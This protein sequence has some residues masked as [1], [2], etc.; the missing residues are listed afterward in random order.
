MIWPIW[1][2]VW[3]GRHRPRPL[4][5]LQSPSQRGG[6]GIAAATAPCYGSG[7]PYCIGVHQFQAQCTSIH[8]IDQYHIMIYNVYVQLCVHTHICILYIYNKM[9]YHMHDVCMIPY[10]ASWSLG[11]CKARATSSRVEEERP[12]RSQMAPS[13]FTRALPSLLM[14][15]DDK[16]K[17][18]QLAGSC[19]EI[20]CTYI[21]T[22][23]TMAQ[24]QFIHHC[25]NEFV[26][27]GTKVR[28]QMCPIAQAST[29]CWVA[30]DG[31]SE[32]Y[33]N[34]IEM[35]C[36]MHIW[37]SQLATAQG[38]FNPGHFS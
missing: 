23:E 7:C 32:I 12:K 17:M 11:M 14:I 1:F 37:R 26:L 19:R 21:I 8:I 4:Q 5:H 34:L 31:H 28:N 36:E 16:Q 2:D 29:L 35:A 27:S 15:P 13:I 10:S 25:V 30:A 38:F 24:G 18:K 6:E 33:I 3:P 9:Y 20:Q 22:T